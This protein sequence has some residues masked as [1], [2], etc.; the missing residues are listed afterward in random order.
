MGKVFNFL[1]GDFFEDFA[2]ILRAGILSSYEWIFESVNKRANLLLEDV[3]KGP[4]DFLG[5]QVY[6]KLTEIVDTAVMPVAG[7]VICF[8]CVYELIQMVISRNSF[9]D[10]ET[11]M[12]FKWVFKTMIAVYFVTNCFEIVNAFFGLVNGMVVGAKEAV[13]DINVPKTLEEFRAEVEAIDNIGALLMLYLEMFL[14]RAVMVAMSVVITFVT[15]G[16]FIDIYITLSVAPIPMA[17]MANRE[18]GQIG[19]NYMKT[20]FAFALQGFFMILCVFIYQIIIGDAGII[21]DIDNIHMNIVTIGG[22]TVAL[23]FALFKTG[24]AAKSIVGA[25]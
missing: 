13:G 3:L 22:M 21:G 12:F 17:T 18:W 10:I 20:F 6:D 11:F 2:N 7:M 9:H 15:F 8:V 4:A 14:F 5:G 16:R 1:F 25:H 23:I 19:V 24:G